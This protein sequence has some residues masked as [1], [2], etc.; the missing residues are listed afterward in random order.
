MVDIAPCKHKPSNSRVE[1]RSMMK[2]V[3]IGV[4]IVASGVP[5]ALALLVDR[6]LSSVAHLPVIGIAGI[7]V[8]LCDA[9]CGQIISNTRWIPFSACHTPAEAQGLVVAFKQYHRDMILKWMMAKVTSAIVVVLTAI[10]ALQKCPGLIVAHKFE[11]F[12]IGYL[13]LGCSMV[14][15]VSFILSYFS[16]SDESDRV[17]LKE[18]NYVYQKEHPELYARNTAIVKKQLDGFG[19][20]YTSSAATA[21]TV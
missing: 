6:D 4:H 7:C 16:A 15:A 11:I 10:M 9:L 3:R 20:G 13:L 5:L 1:E 21:T 17:R 14:M 8:S 12:I 19:A 2:A 18:M